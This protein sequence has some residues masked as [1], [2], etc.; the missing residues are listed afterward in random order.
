MSL[1]TQE[2]DTQLLI[3]A[4]EIIDF[5]NK[6]DI[7]WFPIILEYTETDTKFENGEVKMLKNMAPMD[8]H[9][10]Y[11]HTKVGKS[12]ESYK[13]YKPEPT[14]FKQ[15]PKEQIIKRQN[16]LKIPYW[17]K[18]CNSIAINT[19]N[20]YHIDLDCIDYLDI[21]KDLLK[22][23]PYY[24]SSTKSFGAHIFI[25]PET[26]YSPEKGYLKNTRMLTK[27]TSEVELLTGLWGW[28]PITSLVYNASCEDLSFDLEPYI[29]KKENKGT[30]EKVEN[31]KDE[32]GEPY[33]VEKP[34]TKNSKE[35]MQRL[36]GML[37]YD[38]HT[39]E[40]YR[41]EFFRICDAMKANGFSESDWVNF[42]TKSQN[43]Q[44][45]REKQNL[46]QKCRG[47][48]DISYIK[49]IAKRNNPTEY[50]LWLLET[51]R[52]ININI[53]RKGE[54]DV[55]KFIAPSLKRNL[56]L[57]NE[58]WWT[59]DEATGLWRKLKD[60]TYTVID[61]IQE[62]I[63]E[64]TFLIEY[65]IVRLKKA[66]ILR[67]E[68]ADKLK[69]L[70]AERASLYREYRNVSKS[71]YSSQV[72]RNLKELLVNNKFVENLD[73]LTGQLAFQNGVVDLKTKKFREGIQYDDFITKTIPFDY[74][75]SDH[76]YLKKELKKIM[77]NNDEHL[78][79]FLSLL[80]YSFTAE[81]SVEKDIYFMIDKTDGG[82]GDNGKTFFFNI[83]NT[84]LPNY[85]YRSNAS[86]L[87]SKNTKVHKQITSIKGKRWVYLEELPKEDDLN[88]KLIK[89]LAD[90]TFYENEIMFGTT[91]TIK[92]TSKFF[93]LSNHI[94]KIDP[95]E[96]AV[97]NRYKQVS[98]NSHFDR[99]GTRKVEEPEKLLFIA[100]KDLT[101]KIVDTKRDEV[102]S[103]IIEYANKFYSSKL[104]KIPDQFKADTE[105][106]KNTNDEFGIWSKKFLKFS[107]TGKIS[108]VDMMEKSSLSLKECTTGMKR[109]GIK[110]NKDLKNNWKTDN[111]MPLKGG[112]VGMKFKTIGELKLEYPDE[113]FEDEDEASCIIDGNDLNK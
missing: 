72:I 12:G 44:D 73:V 38:K 42:Y 17:K 56:I 23:Y 57:C 27:N 6:H 109:L 41:T 50:H 31:K 4:Q 99:T 25:K 5:C 22:T 110:Y 26:K 102:V 1:T 20:I 92:I 34:R 111:G 100:D 82:R 9:E 79:Y 103:I 75:E 18:R 49:R 107:T 74:K 35:V 68:D 48:T 90:G 112:W 67:E 78:E 61:C 86:L 70:D 46:F 105:E 45:D 85:V 80:G 37:R 108:K 60:P 59:Q 55:A 106:T 11:E 83:L 65:K 62:Y 63:N 95:D 77:N 8:K 16:L 28:C 2:I 3:D 29:V 43:M 113:D 30:N 15:L 91:E 98:F 54:K 87:S 53:L 71:S 40:D 24:K 21:Y 88:C 32:T 39:A 33:K 52:I 76:V 89:E 14:D 96:Q 13:S 7:E 104:P 36:I 93:A 66:E 19:E 47:T 81:A 64:A 101:Q 94:P 69:E 58:E 10:L 51:Q 84:I 97:Y